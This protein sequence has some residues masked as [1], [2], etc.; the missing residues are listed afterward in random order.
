MDN[1]KRTGVVVLAGLFVPC[2]AFYFLSQ[3][4]FWE[5]VRSVDALVL[6][7]AGVAFGV[8]LRALL[9]KSGDR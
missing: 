5:K 6:F 4:N 8:A 9:A 3:A 7:V 2:I 1:K